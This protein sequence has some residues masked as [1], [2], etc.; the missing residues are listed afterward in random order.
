MTNYQV[1]WRGPVLRGG[2]LGTASREYVLALHRLGVDVKVEQKMRR[3]VRNSGVRIPIFIVPH[4]VHSSMFTPYNKK[5]RVKNTAGKFVFVSVF[6]FQH[7]K[8]LKRY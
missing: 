8:I 7:R 6:G 4:G 3:A 5:L 2:G 1:V